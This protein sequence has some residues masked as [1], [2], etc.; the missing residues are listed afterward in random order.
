ME[1][2]PLENASRMVHDCSGIEISKILH[3]LWLI[4]MCWCDGRQLTVPIQD[5]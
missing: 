5:F 2:D 3:N 4:M 1:P